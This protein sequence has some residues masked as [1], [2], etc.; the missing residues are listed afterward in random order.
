[1]FA[2]DV[3]VVAMRN[4]I[5]VDGT[6]EPHDVDV[7]NVRMMNTNRIASTSNIHFYSEVIG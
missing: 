3:S 5:V 2:S 4:F 1:M 6:V 7:Y